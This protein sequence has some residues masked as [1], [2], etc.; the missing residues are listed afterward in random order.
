MVS[1]SV[2]MGDGVMKGS[3]GHIV[4]YSV[5]VS[6]GDGLRVKSEGLKLV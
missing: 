6:F 2:N 4:R 1:G 3:G 5:S